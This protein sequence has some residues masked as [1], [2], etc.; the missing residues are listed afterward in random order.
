MKQAA[1]VGILLLAVPAWAAAEK[2]EK[3]KS[4]LEKGK[5]VPAFEVLDVT[6]PNADTKLC[7]I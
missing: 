4:G 6:G 7:Y 3:P 5:G 1:F 2:A